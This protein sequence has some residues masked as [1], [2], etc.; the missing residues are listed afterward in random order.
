M[1]KLLYID[2]SLIYALYIDEIITSLWCVL[3][4]IIEKKRYILI[5]NIKCVLV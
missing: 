3:A 5:P 1:L 4:Y 2:Y